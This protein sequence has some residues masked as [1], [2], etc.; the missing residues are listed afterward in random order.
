MSLFRR[1][2]SSNMGQLVLELILVA[3][4][5]LLLEILFNLLPASFL[6]STFGDL[7]LNVLAAAVIVVVFIL[8][9]RKVEHSSLAEAGLSK[10]QWP[11]Q[12]LLSFFCGG[13]LI[14]IVILVLAITGSYHITGISPFGAVEFTFFIIALC[15]LTLLFLRS[16]RMGFLHYMLG[17]FLIFGLA[18][19]LVPLL[20]L[21][22]GALQE[23]LIFRGMIFRKLERSF[24]SW[25]ALAISAILF[26]I[27][28]LLNPDATLVSALAI[29]V[30][31][32]VLVA[33]VYILTRSLWWAIGLHLGWNFFEGTVFGA[34]VSGH[35]LPGFFSSVTTGPV[36]WTGGGFGPEAGLA[37]IVIIGAI[38]F[39][40]CFRATRQHRI[41][42]RPA[43]T[44]PS[45]TD[46]PIAQG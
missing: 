44:R 36:A 19:T 31:A 14:T 11:R 17:V 15:L 39:F 2:L 27:S 7:L 30:T 21:I 25:I 23:E 1:I 45:Q 4:P 24:G 42:S 8:A 3:I 46:T 34:Q 26:G 35:N 22:A 20:I 41:L 38:G 18:S 12:L 9:L 37:S 43:T 32:G 28:H 10:Q 29:M 33:A 6:T 16:K 40:L 13:V 5:V